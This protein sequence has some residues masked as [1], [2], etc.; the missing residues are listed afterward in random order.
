MNLKTLCALLLFSS[1]S[2][3]IHSAYAFE[4]SPALPE[5]SSPGGQGRQRAL[6]EHFKAISAPAWA[7]GVGVTPDSSSELIAASQ[8]GQIDMVKALLAGGAL[9][10]AAD[11]LGQ[12]PLL[13]AVAAGHAEIVRLLLQ[14]GASPNVK[15]PQGR[16]P[17]GLASAAGNP[18]I[19]RL[20]L[21][22]GADVDARSDNRATA[23]HEAVRF[24]HPEIVRIL[25]AAAPDSER[26]DREGL[27]PLALAAAQGR[28]A[29]LQALLDSGIAPD[30]P[31]RTG[32]TALYWARRYNQDLA[33]SLLIAQGASREAWPIPER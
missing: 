14:S 2:S 3:I 8:V 17:L 6:P 1:G 27:H 32:L 26:Y 23:L 4:E 5:R 24:D 7:F 18:G 22:A 21:R 10:N 28:L 19:V 11:D 15:G 16:T 20:L 25:I 31:D 33:E 30:L 12:R 9:P 29:C 13:V